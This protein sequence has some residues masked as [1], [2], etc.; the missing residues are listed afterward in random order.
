MLVETIMM[1]K[2]FWIVKFSE[3]IGHSITLTVNFMFLISKSLIIS[4]LTVSSSPLTN[5]QHNLL[6]ISIHSIALYPYPINFQYLS[7]ETLLDFVQ[8]CYDFI[9]FS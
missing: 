7:H 6:S 2:V 9:F 1:N 4:L 5:P 8:Y 3:L